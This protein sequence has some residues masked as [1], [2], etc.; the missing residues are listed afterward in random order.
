[1]QGE[2]ALGT[3]VLSSRTSLS[4]I[5]GYH[6][7]QIP[8]KVFQRD[9]IKSFQPRERLQRLAVEKNPDEIAVVA[10]P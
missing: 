7:V 2:R 4:E 9:H 5:C 10:L 1:M 3:A 8:L 6:T